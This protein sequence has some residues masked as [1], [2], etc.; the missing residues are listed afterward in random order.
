MYKYHL[1]SADELGKPLAKLVHIMHFRWTVVFHDLHIHLI[2]WFIQINMWHKYMTSFAFS[3]TDQ[4]WFECDFGWWAEQQPC[5][6][7]HTSGSEPTTSEH[8]QQNL[9]STGLLFCCYQTNC[10]ADASAW[11]KI[12]FLCDGCVPYSSL[13]GFGNIVLRCL[14]KEL[15][16]EFWGKLYSITHFIALN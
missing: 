14:L 5:S 7:R 2:L 6:W 8:S 9:C 13:I 11:G 10:H 3:D 15:C 12:D 16:S 1:I 4:C